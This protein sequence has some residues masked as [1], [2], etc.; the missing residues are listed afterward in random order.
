VCSSDP[1]GGR[2]RTLRVEVVTYLVNPVAS[3]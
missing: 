1:T 3:W 2:R